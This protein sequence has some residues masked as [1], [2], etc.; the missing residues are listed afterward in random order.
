M[1]SAGGVLRQGLVLPALLLLAGFVFVPLITLGVFSLHTTVSP[2]GGFTWDQYSTFFEESLYLRVLWKT[3]Y[4][5]LLVT[6]VAA[7]IAWPAGWIVS[8]LSPRRQVTVLTLVI[9]PYL[10]S[11]LLL[12]YAMFVAIAPR[13]P[14][15]SFL[16]LVGFAGEESSILYTPW[17]TIA[18]L[19]YESVPIMLLLMYAGSE[20]ISDSL[21]EAARSLGAGRLAVFRRVVLPLSL[22]SL[23]TGSV[24][25]FIPILGAFA[26]PA[27]LGGP[28]GVLIGNIINDQINVVDN[29]PFAAALCFVILGALVLVGVAT[30]LGLRLARRAAR[31]AP[32]AVAAAP[33]G[34]TAA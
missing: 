34:G 24:L 21:L 26:E 29:Q 16:G 10:T 31:P 27:I 33:S 19:I 25:V 17:A 1:P 18:M 3:A 28:D 5:A 2:L 22:P 23:L 9:L 30:W 4:T 7:A 15:M 32:R 8:R 14:V 11:Y 6:A 13:G 20:R 12:I